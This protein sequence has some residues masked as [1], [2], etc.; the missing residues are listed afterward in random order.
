MQEVKDRLLIF[1][2]S[3]KI[4]KA[5]FERRVGMS[6]GYLKNFKGQLGAE[7]LEGILK[8][9]PKL[10]RV[11]LL[12]GEGS[13]LV[14][15]EKKEDVPPTPVVEEAPRT[16]LPSEVLDFL[17]KSATEEKATLLEVVRS[18][19]ET[20]RSQAATIER[21]ATKSPVMSAI[22]APSVVE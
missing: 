2:S 15:V 4:S 16:L 19:Q 8:A 22:P 1:V 18:Q 20:I 3:L 17:Y 6:N 14:D 12:T 10:S 7:K 5:E 13:M 9:F 21:L 11:W